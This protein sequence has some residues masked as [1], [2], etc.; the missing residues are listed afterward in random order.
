MA[1]KTASTR[2]KTTG[3]TATRGSRSGG[4]TGSSRSTGRSAGNR[5][6]KGRSGRPPARRTA[7]RSRQRRGGG[8]LARGTRGMWNVLAKG[9]GG[10]ARTVGRTKELEPAHRRD[11]L[12]LVYIAFGVI[13]AAGVWFRGAGPVGGYIE[14]GVRTVFGAAAIAMPLLLLVV[15]I[16][17]MRTEPTPDK[18]PRLVIGG[19]LIGAALLGLMHLFAGRPVDNA[20]RMLAGGQIGYLTGG[21]LAQGLTAWVAAPLLVLL[22]V[23]GLLVITGTPVRQIPERI[24][25][26]GAEEFDPDAEEADLLTQDSSNAEDTAEL[27]GDTGARTRLRRPSR[28]RQGSEAA[29][30][31]DLPLVGAGIAGASKPA[32]EAAQAPASAERMTVTP[33]TVE[34]DYA[35]PP[36][37]VLEAGDAPKSRSKAND[38]M[39]EAIGGVLAEFNL[40]AQVTGFTRGPTVTRYEVELGPGVKVEKITTL[41]KNIAYAAATDNIRLLAPIPGKS[42]VGIEVPNADREMVRLGDVLRSSAAGKDEHPMVIGLGK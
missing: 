3:A 1:N 36:L 35:L 27:G 39:I 28:R 11:G 22:L 33:R 23:Y 5:S 15:A 21:F 25:T 12:A 41:S 24:R 4:S 14:I 40:D 13:L 34:G 8:S 17:L 31:D 10:M 16:V 2:R 29:A 9:V 42:A 38:A 30:P 19:L 6:R 7:A 32:T 20:H 18:R 26:L 37:T